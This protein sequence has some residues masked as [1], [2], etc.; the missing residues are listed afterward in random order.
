MCVSMSVCVCVCVQVVRYA[1][2][3]GLVPCLEEPPFAPAHPR[4]VDGHP[5]RFYETSAIEQKHLAKARE[6]A[7]TFPGTLLTLARGFMEFCFQSWK[8]ADIFIP[9]TYP[10]RNIQP[11]T[12]LIN[13]HVS[14]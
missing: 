13:C 3:C 1:Q 6:S 2:E 11:H 10:H 14:A 9:V 12:R 5:I 8:D 4:I 7:R